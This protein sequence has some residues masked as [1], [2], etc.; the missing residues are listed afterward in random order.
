V[1]VRVCM[2]VCVGVCDHARARTKTSHVLHVSVSACTTSGTY[3]CKTFVFPMTLDY[4]P[5]APSLMPA[6]WIVLFPPVPP[7]CL[8]S[9]NGRVECSFVCTLACTHLS[10][11]TS[12]FASSAAASASSAYTHSRARRSPRDRSKH[13][14]WAQKLLPGSRAQKLHPGS[15]Q[16]GP[17]ESGKS[18]ASS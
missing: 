3:C 2:R 1:F 17:D 14:A 5:P 16:P 13:R 10:D 11:S 8:L 12:T 15:S 9:C 6:S 4:L 18:R 7:S